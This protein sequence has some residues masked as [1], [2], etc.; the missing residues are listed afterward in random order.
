[1]VEIIKKV[2]MGCFRM[3]IWGNE[4]EFKKHNMNHNIVIS[5]RKKLPLDSI[6]F[7]SNQPIIKDVQ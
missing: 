5:I 7:N 1:M 3:I 6:Q 4:F 2:N